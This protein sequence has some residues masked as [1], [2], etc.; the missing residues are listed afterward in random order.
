VDSG[1]PFGHT[2]QV[3]IPFSTAIDLDMAVNGTFCWGKDNPSGQA[4]RTS[5]SCAWAQFWVELD[6]AAQVSAYRDFLQGYAQA[7]HAAGRFQ[8]PAESHLY[9]ML[10]WLDRADWVPGDLRLQLVLALAFLGVSLLNIV[11]LLLAKFLRR[12]GEISVR[13]ALGARRRDIFL[14]LGAESV[15]IGTLGGVLGLLL[16]QAGLWSVR[17]R[18]DDYATLARMDVG[19][20]FLTVG[21]AVLASLL[22]GLLP[23][24]RACRVPPALQLKSA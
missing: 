5:G 1:H 10:T 3:F 22:A 11:A 7:Q 16:A 18:P 9:P 23:A 2:D 14:Q 13:R 19:M 17:Q 21:L 8:R 24:W 12:S 6:D 15:L 4:R 20:L